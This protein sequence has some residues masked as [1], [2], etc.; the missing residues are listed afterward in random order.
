MAP[1]KHDEVRNAAKLRTTAD[2]RTIHEPASDEDEYDG[3][4][5]GELSEGD[6]D[7]LESEDERERLLT[8]KDGLSGMFNRTG[9]GVKIGKRSKKQ[10]MK[11]R[12][13][14]GNQESSALM[15][16]MEE[17]IGASTSSLRRS[18]ESDEERL[19]AL[20]LQAKVCWTFVSVGE[21]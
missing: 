13:R 1:R 18:E 11:E 9:L 16:E 3:R 6:H 5:S 21:V 12:R 15:Y 4:P 14:G 17:G 8:Q 10:E 2:E 7:I 19:H 20:R